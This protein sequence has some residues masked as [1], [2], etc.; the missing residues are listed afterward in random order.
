MYKKDLHFF[1]NIPASDLQLNI[2]FIIPHFI[3]EEAVELIMN[4]GG[5][6]RIF[7]LTSLKGVQACPL[8]AG[9][10]HTA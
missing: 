9:N 1:V 3:Q 4:V 2:V 10:I 5:H 7:S 6:V 8:P